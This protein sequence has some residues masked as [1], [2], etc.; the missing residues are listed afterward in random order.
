MAGVTYS[1]TEQGVNEYF[2]HYTQS[3]HS[4]IVNYNVQ[5]GLYQSNVYAIWH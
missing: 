4:K 3:T 1:P 2:E 5:T